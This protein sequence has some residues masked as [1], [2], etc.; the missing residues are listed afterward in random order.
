[1]KHKSTI[2]IVDDTKSARETLEDLL[3]PEGYNIELAE[4]G[5]QAL[6]K[7]GEIV[8]DLILLDVMMPDMDGFE[9]CSK[10]R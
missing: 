4:N 10:I 5:K 3:S 6:E 2:L 7:A 9:V 8:P 1:M